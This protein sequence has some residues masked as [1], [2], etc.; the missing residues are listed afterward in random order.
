MTNVYNVGTVTANISSSSGA[1]GGLVGRAYSGKIS[2]AYNAGTVNNSSSSTYRGGIACYSDHESYANVYWLDTSAAS[3]ITNKTTLTT[4]ESKMVN[5]LKASDMPDLLNSTQTTKIWTIL[6]AM[7]NGFPILMYQKEG[8]VIPITITATEPTGKQSTVTATVGDGTWSIVKYEFY[9]DG[10]KVGEVE[11]TET[12]ATLTLDTTFYYNEFSAK[13]TAANGDIGIVEDP[14]K[15]YD[16]DIKVFKELTDFMYY[17]E[18]GETYENLK[19]NLLDSFDLGHSSSN[20]TKSVSSSALPFAGTF[21]GN[22][23]TIS[24][25]YINVT[26]GY[27][28]FFGKTASTATIKNLT[29][30]GSV[31]GASYTGGLV[32][33]NLGNIDNCVNKC[34]IT[35]YDTSSNYHGGIAG[36]SESGTISNCIN[37][38]TIT[39]YRYVGGITGAKK[40]GVIIGCRN[41]TASDATTAAT[42]KASYS[43]STAG[44]RADIAGIVGLNY[45]GAI[46]DCYNNMAI[47]GTGSYPQSVAGIVAYSEGTSPI[48]NCH[49]EGAI[50]GKYYYIAGI[51][52]YNNSTTSPITNC[53]N[54]AN[55]TNSYITTYSGGIVGRSNSGLSNVSNEGNITGT[56]E[57]SYVGGIAGRIEA[58]G[59]VEATSV[60]DVAGATSTYVGGIVGR[61]IAGEAEKLTNDGSVTGQRYVAGIIGYKDSTD[62]ITDCRNESE[63]PETITGTYTNTGTTSYA[64]IAGIVGSNAGGAIT[65]CY[66]NA[67]IK[68]T[69]SYSSGVAGIAGYN[70]G[71]APIT[72][73]HNEANVSTAY[74]YAGGIVGNHVAENSLISNCSSIGNVSTRTDSAHIGGIAGRSYSG[75]SNVLCEGDVTGGS[76]GYIGGVVGHVDAGEIASATH[77]GDVTASSG[78]YVGGIVGYAAAGEIKDCVNDGSV[79]GYRYIGGIAG[80]K[81]ATYTITNCKNESEDAETVT[82]TYS[83]DTSSDYAGVAGVIGRNVGG[84]ITD[85]YNNA[86]VKGTGSYSNAIGGIVGIN[87]GTSPITNCHNE[88]NVSTAYYYAGGIAGFHASENALISNCSSKGNVT[89]RSDGGNVGGLAGRS[90]SG[91]KDALHEGDIT[92]GTVGHAGGIVGYLYLGELTNCT[93]DGNVSGYR[94]VGGICGYKESTSPITNC[95]NE[96]EDAE[97]VTGTYS[98][99]TVGNYA[100]IAGVVG[101]NT[102]GAITD[103]YNN[104]EIKGTGNQPNAIG[105]IVGL[106]NGTSP[107]TN[108]HNEANVSTAYYYAGG[109]AGFHASENALITNCS[110]KGNISARSDSAYI[111]GI[112][113]RSYSGLSTVSNEGNITGGSN[114][115][116]GGVAGN[117]NAGGVVTATNVGDVTGPSGTYIAGVVGYL[118]AGELKDCTN[119]GSISGYR[120]VSGICGYKEST[121]PITNCRNESEDAE[122]ITGTYSNSSTG[123]YAGVAGIVGYNTGGAITDCYNNEEIKGTGTY[124]NGVGGIVGTNVG[125]APITN[126]HNIGTISNTYYYTGGI[127]AYHAATSSPITK[128][129][130]IGSVSASHAEAAYVA[131]IAGRSSSEI[132]TSYNEGAIT[133]PIHAGGVVGYTI[134]NVVNVYNVG[135]ITG[136]TAT[137]SYSTGGVAAYIKDAT[138]KHAYNAGKVT[139]TSSSTCVGGVAGCSSNATFTNTYYL[140]TSCTLAISNT[141]STGTIVK[142]EAEMKTKAMATLL[143]DTQ[144]PEVWTRRSSQNNGYPILLALY[145]PTSILMAEDYDGATVNGYIFGNSDIDARR[146]NIKTITFVDIM[147]NVAPASYEEMWD[148]S[149]ELDET[150]MLYL[151]ANGT[152]ASGNTAYDMYICAEGEIT[153][154]DCAALLCQYTNCTAINNL[155]QLDVTEAI[156]MEKMFYGDNALA[157]VDI[158][159]LITDS[160]TTMKD[161]FNGCHA[162]T[163]IDVSKFNTENVT[164]MSGMFAECKAIQSLPLTS[165]KTAAVTDMS[166]MFNNCLAIKELKLDS[167]D[168]SAVTNMEGMFAGCKALEGLDLSDFVV[169]TS[170]N[171]TNLLKGSSKLQSVVLGPNFNNLNGTG[172]FEDTTTLRAIMLQKEI[173]SETGAPSLATDTGVEDVTTLYVLNKTQEGY[174]EKATNYNTVFGAERI[175]P[176]LGLDGKESVVSLIGRDYTDIGSLVAGFK[177][178][179]ATNY[180]QYG[181]A[182]T[183]ENNIVKDTVGEYTYTY[184]LTYNDSE[185][186]RIS[187]TVMVIVDND[188]PTVVFTT[189]GTNAYMMNVATIVTVTDVGEA[190]VDEETLKYVWTES[191]TEPTDSEFTNAFTNGEELSKDEVNGTWYLWVFASDNAGNTVKAKSESFYLDN[192][193]PRGTVKIQGMSGK[194]TSSPELTVNLSTTDNLVDASKIKVALIEGT[195]DGISITNDEIKWQDYAETLTTEV[196]NT[197]GKKVIFV[198]FKDEAG[199]QTLYVK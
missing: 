122:T 100:G 168:T 196:S 55:I 40:S 98:S 129:S 167:F 45:D 181:Y 113:G 172:M 179:E 105:G 151:V 35:N 47:S 73:C 143:N 50:T 133:G 199:N 81:A 130:N 163:S 189:N 13:V 75:L 166:N 80:G 193:S 69:G 114:G 121:S 21:D 53:S 197:E 157:T 76:N 119:D 30:A 24:G 191:A 175:K 20:Q 183:S 56:G 18:N 149:Q 173:A 192:V 117:V 95:R 52:G 141:T 4:I 164:D 10:E 139:N 176:I 160:I 14:V 15:V 70:A 111:G 145:V 131:G 103:C 26:T 159:N 54:K 6:A 104:A 180:T 38:G 126:S 118:K 32:G 92:G 171:V 88:A 162:L 72:N 107:I 67:T 134:A 184:I 5:E 51:V 135:N 83:S 140:D 138:M 110:S 66:N 57:G 147:E 155:P 94:Y 178:N 58:G 65:N 3:G 108:S 146:E 132:N 44:Y 123:N 8:L 144:N 48:T 186:D 42:I 79:S 137:A 142:T 39:A 99:S 61:L 60:G 2:Y 187:R 12:N 190:G 170:T 59:I 93:N 150:V 9:K 152:D 106:N 115:Y 23:N 71:T 36:Y 29:I 185:V 182:V 127:V 97:T 169:T 31:K 174:F 85:C 74:Y 17:G 86:E 116:I 41:E 128:C 82:G 68:A 28:G 89:T 91:F 43:S 154:T 156:S 16:A 33:Y 22:N 46:T 63:D 84:A 11:S 87:L 37:N 153:A 90:Y 194:Y 148:V 64:G 101:Y 78:N 120:Y 1:P 195:D 19:I 27:A 188:A 25:I 7:N 34:T 109:I 77:I 96:S 102:G 49:N 198:I 158:S 165:F 177:Q 124:C 112:V 161:M 136:K 62:A 125:T